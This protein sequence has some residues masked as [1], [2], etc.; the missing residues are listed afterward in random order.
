MNSYNILLSGAGQLG[1]RYLQGLAKSKINLDIY[2]YDI[3]SNSLLNAK[4]RLTEVDSNFPN[5]NFKFIDTLEKIPNKIDL[6][7][8][9]TTADTRLNAIQTIKQNT[10]VKFWI[11]EKFWHKV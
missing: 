6:A 10:F 8:V 3:N 1:S 7:I 4:E 5:L 11:L 9:T 2:I